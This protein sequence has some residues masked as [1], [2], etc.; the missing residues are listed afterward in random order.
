MDILKVNSTH[1]AVAT[2]TS[3]T[4]NTTFLLISNTHLCLTQVLN[5][6]HFLIDELSLFD[7]KVL[8]GKEKPESQKFL[9]TEA[10][11]IGDYI[12]EQ[13]KN[14]SLKHTA[15]FRVSG[16]LGIIKSYSMLYLLKLTVL[17]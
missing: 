3:L 13:L 15:F 8:S 6:H 1:L 10:Q 11:E 14:D 7:F 17:E 5:L 12:F 9:C 2:T 4:L 16:N